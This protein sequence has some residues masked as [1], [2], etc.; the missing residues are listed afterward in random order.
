MKEGTDH[1]GSGRQ[2]GGARL[3][4]HRV[5]PVSES[6][7]GCC[8]MYRVK[9][10]NDEVVL[11]RLGSSLGLLGGLLLL[12]QAL[13]LGL[14]LGRLVSVLALLVVL[15]ILVIAVVLLGGGG[16]NSR[17]GR[18]SSNGSS[19]SL[20]SLRIGQGG[21]VVNVALG[22]GLGGLGVGLSILVELA[23]GNESFLSGGSRAESPAL[24]IEVT[25]HD[26]KEQERVSVSSGHAM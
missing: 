15:L 3:P 10:Q 14:L 23:A 4:C 18:S 5:V 6:S 12:L 16:L 9:K 20:G 1:N 11:S 24:G 26:T 17:G 21:L 2:A 7:V 8:R 25:V 19:R 22:P 13:S